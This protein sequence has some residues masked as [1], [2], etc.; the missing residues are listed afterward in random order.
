VTISSRKE[1]ITP[2]VISFFSD[3][4]ETTEDV[5]NLLLSISV[6]EDGLKLW[7]SETARLLF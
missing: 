1:T 7:T 6:E 3:A 5:C 2:G 4:A